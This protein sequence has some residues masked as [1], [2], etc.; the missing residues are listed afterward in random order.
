MHLITGGSGFLGASL[1][2]ALW[3]RGERVRVLDLSDTPDRPP[4]VEFHRCDILDR[5]GVRRAMRGVRVVHHDVSLV[6][7]TKSGRR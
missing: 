2:R 6:P 7:L 3:E 1:A 5:E 4:E